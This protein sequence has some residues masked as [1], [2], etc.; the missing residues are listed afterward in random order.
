MGSPLGL[1]VG[2]RYLLAMF[3]FYFLVEGILGSMY[4][5]GS[6]PLFFFYF[7]VSAIE[8]QKALVLGML[9]WNAV[10]LIGVVANKWP[11][12]GYYK[13]NITLVAAI[14]V[15]PSTLGIVLSKTANTAIIFFACASTC[16][17]TMSTTFDGQ[18]GP[19]SPPATEKKGPQVWNYVFTIVPRAQ[20]R[21]ADFVQ[22]RHK[23]DRTPRRG[24]DHG[25]R[26]PR[27]DYGGSARRH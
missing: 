5:N 17:A 18:Y 24:I 14:L 3:Q 10:P 9:M 16:I 19:L 8:Y 4:Y 12:L 22:D 13:R 21:R 27:R 20:E 1:G 26:H 11:I 25:W 6:L 2:R 23:A 7:K 15:A